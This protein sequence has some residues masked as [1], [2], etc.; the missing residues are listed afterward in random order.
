MWV[1]S[2]RTLLSL[3][4]TLNSMNAT[5]TSKVAKATSTVRRN[6]LAGIAASLIAGCMTLVGPVTPTHADTP[7]TTHIETTAATPAFIPASADWLTSV[8]YYRAMSGLAPI[9]ENPAFDTG[10][11]AHSCYMLSNGISHNETP[12]NPGY[13]PAGNESGNNSNVAVSSTINAT[14]RSFIELWMTGPFHAIGI[15][16][17]GLTS[18]GFGRCDQTSTP[19]WH[20]GATLDVLHGLTSQTAP[21]Q[22]ILF[23]G[24]ATTTN[25]NR[26]IAETPNP[27]DACAWTGTAGLPVLAMLPEAASG[28]TSTITGPTGPIETCT[29]TTANTTGTAQQ[30]LAA[31]NAVV[32]IPRTVLAD[33]TY[34]VTIHTTTRDIAWDFTV[35][36]TATNTTKTLTTE[37]SPTINAT[38]IGNPSGFQPVTP[39][40]IV[41]TRTNTGATSFQPG[42]TQRIHITGT[43]GVPTGA[44][45]VVANIT[46]TEATAAGFVTLWNCAGTTPNTS[47]LNYQTG[48]NIPNSATIPLDPTGAICATSYAPTQ[49]IIDIT[50]YTAPT[51][52]GHY[53]PITPTRIMDT[54]LPLGPTT[55]LTT[56]QTVELK[57]TDTTNIPAE[58]NAVII[59]VT[60]DNATTLGVI[61]IYPCGTRPTASNLNPAPGDT[62]ANLVTTA[63]STTGTICIH[64]QQPTEL[65]I[66]A[67]GYFAPT[68]TTLTTTTPFRFTDTRDTNPALNTGHGP[69]Q[70]VAGQI[71]TIQIAGTRGI[72]TN[73]KAIS[74][75]ITAT[76][77]T[78]TGWIAA[79]PCTTTT[80]TNTNINYN[81]TN[82]VA[83]ATQLTLS[84]T[85]TICILTYTNV[86]L[87][88]DINGWWT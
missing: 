24:A 70:L 82:P 87:I 77:A 56:D 35:D 52:T 68:G 2:P 50:G 18:T 37:A 17:P 67:I 85:G 26:F 60:S 39:T 3:I 79:W 30:L 74:A 1:S 27:L 40:R 22:P 64:T 41:D 19:T 4:H 6:V 20:A 16:R 86:D 65:I 69:T 45:A 14:A 49:L 66:D 29:V 28:A 58:A 13:S 31:A 76:N 61:T 59:N 46:A 32:A 42:V 43:A 33:G 23:P 54:R 10:A 72:N 12:G 21:T 63:T 51:A 57:V 55:R 62:H 11:I 36:Q 78:T 44:T 47:T 80:P 7:A 5:V 73:A 81:P 15:L 8:N 88:I 53:N 71:T 25:L 38:P 34:H 84:T 83:N 9:T 48:Q 75:N